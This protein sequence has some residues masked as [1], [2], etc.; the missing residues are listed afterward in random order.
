MQNELIDLIVDTAKELGADELEGVGALEAD[1]RLFGKD[2]ALDSMGLVTLIVALEQ[3]IEDK[4]D[5]SIA[6]ADEKALSQA[7]SPYR[8]VATLADY[9]AGQIQGG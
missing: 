7:R 6:L 5:A 3:A 2:G 4:Y 9:A 1:S 8:T